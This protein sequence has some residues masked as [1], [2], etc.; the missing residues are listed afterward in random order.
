VISWWADCHPVERSFQGVLTVAAEV[1][2]LLPFS[3][4]FFTRLAAVFAQ[5]VGGKKPL[6]LLMS[7]LFFRVG[8]KVFDA[9][10]KKKN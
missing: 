10:D 1:R 8:D 2:W 5:E 9:L 6:S 7:D 4:Q 3:F